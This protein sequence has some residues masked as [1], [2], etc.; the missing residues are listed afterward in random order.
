MHGLFEVLGSVLD[1][2]MGTSPGTFTYGP[3][4]AVVIS[5][6]CQRF[7]QKRRSEE[8]LQPAGNGLPPVSR[9]AC[10]I[11][12]GV[13]ELFSYSLSS[14]SATGQTTFTPWKVQRRVP[15]CPA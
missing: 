6:L 11:Q 13:Y 7:G 2:S 5:G 4:S 8:M 15:T 10:S 9:E 12:L 1:E 14:R 3:P